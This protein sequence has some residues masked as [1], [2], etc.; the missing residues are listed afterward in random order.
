MTPRQAVTIASLLLVVLV[1]GV[2]VHRSLPEQ[3]KVSKKPA[4][5]SNQTVPYLILL[6]EARSGST[7]LESFFTQNEHVLDFF[8]P[9]D[10]RAF[11][12]VIDT[13]S[14]TED[15]YEDI[16]LEILSNE[17]Q[18]QFAD[19][20]VPSLGEKRSWSKSIHRMLGYLD[21]KGELKA[22]FKIPKTDRIRA[23]LK[24][25]APTDI[26]ALEGMCR[27]RDLIS[28][29]VIRI[30]DISLL[31]KLPQFGCENFKILHLVR[32]P[33]P[34]IQSRMDT[35]GELA[36]GNGEKQSVFTE[37]DVSRAARELCN[38]YLRN[39]RAGLADQFKGKYRIVR[40]EDLASDPLAFAERIYKFVGLR[41]T[42]E[43]RDYITKSSNGNVVQGKY[44]VVRNT[45]EVLE[46]WKTTMDPR[47]VKAVQEECKELFDVFGYHVL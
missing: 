24:A 28:A 21:E 25:A 29:K 43:I 20:N 42:Q 34:V 6:A 31:S 4:R 2:V 14:M 44:E 41:F 11:D 45:A 36:Q 37:E 38:S 7:W 46:K 17:C 30:T 9:L 26:R 12:K 1:C 23:V 47:H 13:E 10:T 22:E 5:P 16:K 35:F 33:R 19:V 3:Y 27:S 40:Y 8:E 15:E 18:C 32:D 39:T